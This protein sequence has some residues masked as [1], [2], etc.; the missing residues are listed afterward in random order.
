MKP[1]T[2]FIAKLKPKEKKTLN[3]L[4]KNGDSSNIR[5]RAHAIL[6]SAQGKNITELATIFQVH[7]QTIS[8]WLDR[9]ENEG[10]DGLAD[11]PRCGAPS[12]LTDS[13]KIVV[14][15]LLKEHPHSPKLVL[16]EI[17]NRFGKTISGK[18]LR[19]IANSAGMSWKRMRKSLKS[20]RDKKAF[21]SAKQD[22][23]KLTAQHR[24]R[25]IDLCFF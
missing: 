10:I 15:E 5:H 4:V 2:R 18:T 3:N 11:S 17:S 19:R 23:K 22:L 24:S 1:H 14:V 13:E 12:I 21:K 8:A 6:L 20:K 25:E 16:A 9:F 7:Y